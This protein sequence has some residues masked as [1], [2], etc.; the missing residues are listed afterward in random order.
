[1]ENENRSYASLSFFPVDSL[2]LVIIFQEREIIVL[3][4]KLSFLV[5]ITLNIHDLDYFDE[6]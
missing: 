6:H 1:L 2:F 4:K 5:F 3:G